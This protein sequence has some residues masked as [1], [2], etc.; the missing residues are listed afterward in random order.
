MLIG[1]CRGPADEAR[2]ADLRVL[3]EQLGLGGAVDF[4]PNV[5]FSE[6]RPRC[7]LLL[8]DWVAQVT[9]KHSCT[10]HVVDRQRLEDTVS[11]RTACLLS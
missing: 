8:P 10:A 1:G 5:P 6:A 3:A 9:K 4:R 2:M 11:S 7:L